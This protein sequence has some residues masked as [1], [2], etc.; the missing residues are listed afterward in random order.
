MPL[1]AL[2]P[3]S[4]TVLVPPGSIADAPGTSGPEAGVAF[5]RCRATQSSTRAVHGL[6]PPLIIIPS[7]SLTSVTA[8][9]SSGWSSTGPIRSA[10]RTSLARICPG[11][12]GDLL[13]DSERSSPRMDGFSPV[14]RTAYYALTPSRALGLL[15]LD[16]K[17]LSRSPTWWS[18]VTS[19]CAGRL[20]SCTQTV[21]GAPHTRQVSTAGCDV[22]A[23]AQACRLSPA[24]RARCCRRSGP[25]EPCVAGLRI[26]RRAIESEVLRV[27]LVPAVDAHIHERVGVLPD[28]FARGV[29]VFDMHCARKHR[30]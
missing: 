16:S 21:A 13:A 12:A 10:R 22:P 20:G 8:N 23:I 19:S 1:Q 17:P 24:P 15:T 2:L 4:R 25:G 26:V 3:G 7:R 28:S 18:P 14:L 5:G 29:G 9:R 27:R 30:L 11:Q 6:G